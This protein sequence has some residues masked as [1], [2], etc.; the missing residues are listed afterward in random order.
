M[1]GKIRLLVAPVLA[2]SA[3]LIVA[4]T[5]CAQSQP[6]SLERLF[7]QALEAKGDEYIELRNQI[8]AS[9]D[10]VSFLKA[11]LSHK[12]WRSAILAEAMWNRIN[13]PQRHIAYERILREA[14][15]TYFSPSRDIR[16][17]KFRPGKFKEENHRRVLPFVAELALKD[18][19][20][21]LEYPK[22]GYSDEFL[23]KYYDRYYD[24]GAY[25]ELLFK[26]LLTDPNNMTNVTIDIQKRPPQ[27][28]S[29]IFQVLMNRSKDNGARR[30]FREYAT[31]RLGAFENPLAQ[32]ALAD[33]LSNDNDGRIRLRAAQRLTDP[34]AAPHLRAALQDDYSAVRV[35]AAQALGRLA[36]PQSVDALIAA[37]KDKNAVVR[38]AAAVA[39]GQIG[40]PNAIEP[41]TISLGNADYD[42]RQ[43]AALAI[44]EIDVNVLLRFAQDKDVRV[45]RP[46]VRALGRTKSH[47][48]LQP[49]VT[50]LQD[51]DESVRAY[52]AEALGE[53]GDKQAVEPLQRRL[54]QDASS[55]VRGT[56]A[57]ALGRL[58]DP[59]AVE[60]LI[61]ALSD[62]AHYVR[63]NAVNALDEIA[64]PRAL[65][66][67]EAAAAHDGDISVRLKAELAVRKI[68]KENPGK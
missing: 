44:G 11:R 40:N 47:G 14:A 64:D 26:T 45:R 8:A 16:P 49:L 39:L 9:K 28:H 62:E 36:D 52:A 53:I 15:D 68:R 43:A 66:A 18:S 67:L 6:P 50:A 2:V 17:R 46:V 20:R 33:I 32:A 30:L 24:E 22:L 34:N 1:C 3:S 41:L 23:E 37:L 65:E 42:T 12:D 63:E 60:P 38:E 21:Y 5:A 4:P 59:R 29:R 7:E 57:E 13:E 54:Q 56:A 25:E 10:A 35:A 55:Y 51:S 61:N 48:V 31:D 19:V 27:E 58:K